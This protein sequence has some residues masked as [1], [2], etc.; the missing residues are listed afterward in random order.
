MHAAWP[1]RTHLR[2]AS[3]GEQSRPTCR[4]E[5]AFGLLLYV[6]IYSD[7]PLVC[8]KDAQKPLPHSFGTHCVARRRMTLDS[9]PGRRVAFERSFQKRSHAL[10]II[11]EH[12]RAHRGPPLPSSLWVLTSRVP[13]SLRRARAR[14]RTG[15]MT[16][17]ASTAVH[18]AP[19]ASLI[20]TPIPG[21][22]GF[23]LPRSLSGTSWPIIMS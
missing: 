10:P 18:A 5:E 4:A 2:H 23:G 17:T 3:R 21:W 22:Q 13:T 12:T 14:K 8:S 11:R 1:P 15:S 7:T 19:T 9:T 6:T 20:S 16:N